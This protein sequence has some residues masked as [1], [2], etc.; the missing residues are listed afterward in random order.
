M[1]SQSE[2]LK[3]W[4]VKGRLFSFAMCDV[5]GDRVD[6]IPVDK[7]GGDNGGC[8]EGRTEVIASR[9]RYNVSTCFVK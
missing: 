3:E 2:S 1:R 6:S 5:E 7:N 8:T 4:A 9:Q